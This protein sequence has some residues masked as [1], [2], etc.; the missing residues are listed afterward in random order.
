MQSAFSESIGAPKIPNVKWEDVGGL[1]ALKEE[2]LC[3]LKSTQWDT[4]LKRS[5][6]SYKD[7]II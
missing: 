2:I 1:A 7:K 5:G 6:L 4:E 3:S